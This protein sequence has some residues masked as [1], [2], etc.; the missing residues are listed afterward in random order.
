MSD[1]TI[2]QLI[3]NQRAKRTATYQ[4]AHAQRDAALADKE[5]LG[6]PGI[7]PAPRLSELQIRSI[8]I[9]NQGSRAATGNVPLEIVISGAVQSSGLESI[10]D[11]DYYQAF[12]AL[13][14]TFLNQSTPAEPLEGTAHG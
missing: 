11:D 1:P 13:A 14:Q 2:Q 4:Q 8:A 10:H 12:L 5:P 6:I 9:K 3:D 7:A